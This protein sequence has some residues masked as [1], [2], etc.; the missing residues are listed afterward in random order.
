MRPDRS[1]IEEQGKNQRYDGDPE[2]IAR[3]MAEKGFDA[4]QTDA[5]GS[6]GSLLA[7]SPNPAKEKKSRLTCAPPGPINRYAPTAPVVVNFCRFR[8]A[9]TPDSASQPRITRYPTHSPSRAISIQASG[10]PMMVM[11]SRP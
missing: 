11:I 7:A 9:L 2:R 5:L 8:P 6:T 4:G 1:A 10:M 3:R